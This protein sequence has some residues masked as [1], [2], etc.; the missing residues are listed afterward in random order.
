MTNEIS[1][2]RNSDLKIRNRSSATIFQSAIPQ[3]IQLSAI[4]LNCGS[5]RLKL[6][7]PSFQQTHIRKNVGNHAWGKG[8]VG[9]ALQ[10]ENMT[11]PGG[12][13]GAGWGDAAAAV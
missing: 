12:F 1:E 11:Y 3:S 9:V 8:G 6:R 10:D 13:F 7:M 5:K 4:L 2:V